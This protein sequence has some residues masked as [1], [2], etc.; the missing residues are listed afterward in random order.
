MVVDR[1]GTRIAGSTYLLRF[2][3]NFVYWRSFLTDAA[4]ISANSIHVA[5]AKMGQITFLRVNMNHPVEDRPMMPS[6]PQLLIVLVI[7]VL[8]FGA[9]RL[10]TLG[11]DLGGAVKGFKKAMSEEEENAAARIEEGADDVVDAT[12]QKSEETKV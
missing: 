7:V 1:D 11:G 5:H 9:K 6:I 4:R 8:L 10:R 12:V 3:L 2:T